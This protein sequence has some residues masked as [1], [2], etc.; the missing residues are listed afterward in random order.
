MLLQQLL[1]KHLLFERIFHR[2]IIIHFGK[3]CTSRH[4]YGYGFS[5]MLVSPYTYIILDIDRDYK[6]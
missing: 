6:L 3:H 1:L 5:R 2:L 4:Y